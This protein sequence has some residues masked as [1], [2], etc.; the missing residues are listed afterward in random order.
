MGIP[1]EITGPYAGIFDKAVRVYGTPI[2]TEAGAF[3]GSIILYNSIE[4]LRSIFKT[5]L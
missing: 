5:C 4:E 1:F 3:K 2:M